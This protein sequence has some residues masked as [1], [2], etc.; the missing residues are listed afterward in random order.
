[1]NRF[2]VLSAGLSLVLLLAACER[3]GDSPV[4]G[5]E[6]AWVRSL[7]PG[8][9][10][11]AGFGVLRN[12]GDSSIELVAFSSPQFG[13][14]SLHRTERT[15]GM[16]TMREIE[17]LVLEPGAKVTL[18]PGGYHLML[19]MPSDPLEEGD[20]VVL[21]ASASDGRVFRFEARVERR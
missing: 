21:E 10:M 9:K 16:S 15:E 12:H 1:M 2:K 7:P 17:K 8:M 11:T 20:G 14:V 3:S 4:L 6:E 18:E 19:M 5:F 13:D